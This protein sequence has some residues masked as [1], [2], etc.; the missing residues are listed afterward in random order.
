MKTLC[1]L[2]C[3][4]L[5][6]LASFAQ[7][8]NIDSLKSLLT[9]ARD[10]ERIKILL[11]LCWEHRFINADTAR[12]FGLEALEMAKKS[13]AYALE[14]EALNY[15]GVTHEAQG[16][17]NDALTFE[18]EAL[19]L[20][21]KVSDDSK[22]AK[23]LNDIGIVYD[24]M[25]DYQKALAYYFE[26][27][28]IF[29]RL[30]DKSKIAMVISNIGIVLKAQKEYQK[31]IVYYHEALTIYKSLG[32]KFGVAACH[33]NLGSVYFYLPNY[34]SSL[35]Y[36]LQ[37]TREF[38]EQN[39]RQFMAASL[40]NVGMAYDKLGKEGKAKE[41]I[42]KALR[43]HEA[44]DNKKELSFMLIYLAEINRRTGEISIGLENAN[45]GLSIAK[46][47]GAR[48]Q[49]MDAL[50]ELAELKSASGDFKGAFQAQ[51]QFINIKDSLFQQEKSRQ[52]AEMQT[53]YETEKKEDAIQLLT[54]ENEI[55]DFRLFRNELITISLL[56]VL[57]GLAGVGYLWKYRIKLKQVAELEQT[58]ATLKETQLQA[59]I[60]SQEDERKRFAADLHD[61]MGQ[62]ISALRLNLSHEPVQQKKVEEAVD[63]LNEM[64]VEIRKIAFNLM[65]Q[66][67]V[68]SGLSDALTEFANRINRTGK[69]QVSIQAFDL[70][71]QIPTQHKIALY[72]I[73]QEWVNNI[74]KYA[75]AS[76]ISIQLVQHESELV[77]IIEDNGCGF[78]ATQLVQSQ[79][80]GWK[81][82][83]S[84]LGLIK[85][86]IEIDSVPGRDGT[87]VVIT[88]PQEKVPDL[89]R[90]GTEIKIPS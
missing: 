70:N 32:N 13:Q 48:E 75:G 57:I 77:I 11:E 82:I 1:S 87:T 25:G 20:R 66:V 19:E 35:F 60:T 64:N 76:R 55:K 31:V 39:I 16:N 61:G 26:A 36:S 65:P 8:K 67:L 22:T 89:I 68:N 52:I 62:M 47:I 84:R 50:K 44:Y 10:E 9:G 56:V 29:E 43:L 37:A 5:L 90:V 73:C 79:G 30:G 33:A 27:R 83:N 72:R 12:Q 85:G 78:D 6:A 59:V 14:A 63:I 41:Y 86:G 88:I 24:E 23:T 53:R 45:R 7:N 42:L 18:L 17:Y 15:V 69:V 2:L 74:L 81:N 49:E 38:E 40:G 51:R 80:N 4:F 54:Q 21:K 28:R 34:D 46:R 71:L 58:R 3:L